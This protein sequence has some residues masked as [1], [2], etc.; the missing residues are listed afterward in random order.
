[1][2]RADAL[3]E[4]LVG[5]VV[6]SVQS[7]KT[8]VL[9]GIAA[10]ALDIGYRLI[11]VLAGLKDDLRMQTA[12]RLNRDLLCRGDVVFRWDGHRWTGTDPPVYDHPLGKGYHGVLTSCWSPHYKDDAHQDDAFGV[13]VGTKLGRGDAVLVVIKKHMR[14]LEAVN[15]AFGHAR[16]LHGP[17]RLPL[18]ILDDECDEASTSSGDDRPT[19]ESIQEL[20]LN[21]P[22]QTSSYVGF[23]ATVAANILQSPGQPL[24]PK[25]FIDL[26]RSPGYE[27]TAVT[28]YEPE[29]D[30]RYCGGAT[31]YRLLDDVG[32]DNFFLRPALSDA[33]QGGQPGATDGLANALVAY[34]VSGAIR[35]AA[36]PERSLTDPNRLQ[37]PHS[38]IIHADGAIE[39]HRTMA[40]RLV[41]LIQQRSGRPPS[42][43]P[44]ILRTPP[45]RRL[46][47]A[48]LL[49]WLSRDTELWRV[50]HSR[51]DESRRTLAAIFPSRP[52]LT[53]PTWE[54]TATRLPEVFSSTKLRIINSD[55]TLDPPLDYSAPIGQSGKVLPLDL[56]SIV[57]GGNRLSRGLTIEGLSIS[58]YTRD[59]AMWAED[60][61][62]QRERW[63]GYRGAHLEFCRVFLNPATALRLRRF[64]E[65]DDDLRGQFAWLLREDR[66]PT[67]T[68]FRLMCLP[69][70]VPT[71]RQARGTRHHM[72]LS[73]ARALVDRVQM[74]QSPLEREVAADNAHHAERWWTRI[75][76]HGHRQQTS[77]GSVLGW[78]LRDLAVSE[79]LPFLDGF[80]YTFHN[81][82]PSTGTAKALDRYHRPPDPRMPAVRG[83][84]T[85]DCPFLIAAY[86]RFWAHAYAVSSAAGPGR[87]RGADGVTDWVPCEPPRFNVGFRFGELPALDAFPDAQLLDRTVYSDGTVG[88]RWG[89]HGI[90][91]ANF[92][93]EWFDLPPPHRDRT[94]PRPKGVPGL[95]LLHVVH[96]SADGRFHDGV[97]YDEH[98]PFVG[99]CVPQGGPAFHCI[100]TAPD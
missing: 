28:Y 29:P 93:D 79:V 36:E 11:V 77:S 91:A 6:G 62:V 22:E 18:L 4:H 17:Q 63:F 3:G 74:G 20:L 25:D 71:G 80:A 2:P 13:T 87:Y 21:C 67:E 5:A 66:Q 75:R 58:Y 37:P 8:G 44:D 53:I 42:A 81:P 1:L 26:A 35:L 100:I 65:H 54:T 94:Q 24:F 31:F 83:I 60:T 47:S 50:W 98:R 56:Y 43:V 72:N 41:S 97:P 70:S 34:F 15:S 78:V 30:R 88:S 23:T 92:G 19:A 68:A 51:F 10:K 69:D 14:S 57:I 99:V 7:G 95:L 84:S 96:K 73:G 55:D 59:S 64:H 85:A 82:D 86:L 76:A 46:A 16:R 90:G 27:D 49:H 39:H 12:R 48:D 61:T 40:A 32:Q 38:M 33:E 45:D 9:G 52:S 89:G